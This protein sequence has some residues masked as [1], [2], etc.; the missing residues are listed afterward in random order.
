M[1]S[2]Y[3]YLKNQWNQLFGWPSVNYY[4]F[5]FSL[6][7]QLIILVNHPLN[8]IINWLTFIG[9]NFGVLCLGAL[10]AAKQVNGWLGLIA[11]LCFTIIAWHAKNYLNLISYIIFIVILYYPIIISKKWNNNTNQRI[12]HFNKKEWIIA[13]IATIIIYLISGYLIQF[14]HIDYLPWIDASTLATGISG[15]IICYLQYSEQYIWWLLFDIFNVILWGFSFKA[16]LA[17]LSMSINNIIYIVNDILAFKYSP[18]FEHNELH[19]H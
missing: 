13:T 10:N 1:N 16:G 7:C 8:S 17:T 14:T 9:V 15:S 11:S 18:W 12:R 5:F 3:K 6:G 2:I 19:R 4:L